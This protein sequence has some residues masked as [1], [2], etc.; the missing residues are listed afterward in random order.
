MSRTYQN[1][2]HGSPVELPSFKPRDAGGIMGKTT[3]ALK[4]AMPEVNE[5]VQEDTRGRAGL[6]LEQ[7][8]QAI[9]G[10]EDMVSGVSGGIKD[11]LGGLIPK[12]V[13]QRVQDSMA[14][15]GISTG[16]GAMSDFIKNR[17]AAHLGLTSL[18]MF[19]RGIGAAQDW[20]KTQRAVATVDPLGSSALWVKPETVAGIEQS[21]AENEY[22]SAYNRAIAAAAPDPVAKAQYE[23]GVHNRGLSAGM[24]VAPV[25]GGTFAERW[26]RTSMSRPVSTP[27]IQHNMGGYSLEPSYVTPWSGPSYEYG[28]YGNIPNSP[29]T[30]NPPRGASLFGHSQGGE[31]HWPNFVP[32]N[33][34]FP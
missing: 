34:V 8:K 2:I 17:T 31:G 20:M 12:D 16:T 32:G 25:S 7:L 18:D 6:L 1:Q 30:P 23:W 19:N 11:M 5:L 10:Y 24:S 28:E 14:A 29:V 9:P 13:V 27:S 3:K 15:S 4:G 21:N 22:I 33:P 26:A